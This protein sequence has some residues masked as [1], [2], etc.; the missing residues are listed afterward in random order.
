MQHLLARVLYRRNPRA[1]FRY[2]DGI[3]GD[4]EASV[5]SSL[6]EQKTD[7]CVAINM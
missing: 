2:L 7:A 3:I 6:F 4:V 5:E 1:A